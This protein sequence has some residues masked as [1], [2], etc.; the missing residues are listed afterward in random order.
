VVVG[1]G[2][3]AVRAW[4]RE[5]FDLVLMDIQLPEMG[6]LEATALIRAREKAEGRRT[7]IVALT[8]CAMKGDPERCLQAGMDDYLTKP[9]RAEEL[10]R[11]LAAAARGCAGPSAKRRQGESLYAPSR[12]PSEVVLDR[13]DMLQ[14][15]GGDRELLRRLLELFDEECPRVLAEVRAALAAGDPPRLQRAAHCVKGM[16]GTLGGKAASEEAG[17]LEA[18]AA[19]GDVARAEEGCAALE[20]AVTR[21]SEALTAFAREEQPGV[22]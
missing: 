4:E 15:V 3:E 10:F 22:R 6:G 14:R 19:T 20:Q 5:P 18:L 7:P 9:L 13:A 1:T 17:H 2:Q 11:I 21:L 8:A 16:V 12:V